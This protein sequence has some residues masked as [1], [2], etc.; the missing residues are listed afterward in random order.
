MYVYAPDMQG[1]SHVCM[2]L[3]SEWKD[4]DSTILMF[5]QHYLRT[6]NIS[7][8]EVVLHTAIFYMHHIGQYCTSIIN[9]THDHK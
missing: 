2:C 9:Q 5:G 4:P 7:H 3:D 6:Q 1:F 8:A